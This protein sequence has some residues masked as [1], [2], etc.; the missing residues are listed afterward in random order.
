MRETKYDRLLTLLEELEKVRSEQ[1]G[2]DPHG[3][4]E[5]HQDEEIDRLEGELD[6]VFAR[7]CLAKISVRK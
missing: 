6:G 1:I 3:Y 4:A 5:K 2:Y 7:I